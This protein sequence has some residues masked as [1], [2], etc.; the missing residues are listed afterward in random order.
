MRA[1][2]DEKV[3]NIKS[4]LVR[5]IPKDAGCRRTKVIPIMVVG[6]GDNTN[7]VKRTSEDHRCRHSHSNDSE[8]CPFGVSKDP[9][10]KVLEM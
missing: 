5:E 3:E 10:R 2:E 1:K 7:K 6:I 9:F 8:M 4:D